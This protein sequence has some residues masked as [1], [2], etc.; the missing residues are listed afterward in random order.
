MIYIKK[1]FQSNNIF[2]QFKLKKKKKTLIHQEQMIM[3]K[4]FLISNLINLNKDNKD[5]KENKKNNVN[6]PNIQK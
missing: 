2:E 6:Y 1:I 5:N 4:N 3:K